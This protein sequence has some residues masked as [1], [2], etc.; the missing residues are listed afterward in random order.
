M[1]I[2]TLVLGL[3]SLVRLIKRYVKSITIIL[4]ILPTCVFAVC[5]PYNG[6]ATINEIS[7]IQQF[8][9]DDDDFLELRLLDTDIND[10]IYD[11]WSI[12]ICDS[13]TAAPND[14]RTRSVSGFTLMSPYLVWNNT[15]RGSANSFMGNLTLILQLDVLLVDENGLVIDYLS[16]NGHNAQ[17]PTASCTPAYDTDIYPGSK[18]K[19]IRRLPD[20]T[21]D[22]S[23]PSGNSQPPTEGDSNTPPPAGAA[24][25]TITDDVVIQGDNIVFELTLSNGNYN[26]D[27]TYS[28]FD[29]TATSGEDYTAGSGTISFPIGVT[30]ATITVPTFITTATIAENFYL[31]IENSV[32][33]SVPDGIAV[34]TITPIINA[35]A[36]WRSDEFNYNSTLDEI[37]DSSGNGY[38]GTSGYTTATVPGKVCQAFDFSANSTSDYVVMDHNSLNGLTDFT[39]STWI[40]TSATSTQQEILQGLGTSANDD[41][42]EIALTGNSN[43]FIKLLDV[44]QDF[45]LAANELTD[46]N[47]HHIAFTRSS[48]VVCLYID[49]A[50]K[51]CNGGY[52]TGALSIQANSLIIGQEQ[53]SVGGSFDIS[54]DFEG[55]IDEILIFDTPFLSSQIKDIFLNQNA[56]NEWDGTTRVCPAPPATAEWR[57]DEYTYSG[58]LGEII[59]SSLNGYHGQASGAMTNVL[60]KQ[61][62]AIDFSSD[63]IS[64]YAVLDH[65]SID[66][67]GD[68]T[69]SIWI[70]TS[71][72]TGFQNIIQGM[73]PGGW[74][75][76]FDIYLTDNDTLS[77]RLLS[78]TG[79]WPLAINQ[80]TDGAWHHIA[81][82]RANDQVCLYTDGT[83]EFCYVGYPTGAISLEPGTLILG[84]EQDSFGGGFDA[85]Q[86]FQGYM[87]EPLLFN[88]SKTAAEIQTIYNNQ[89][90]GINWDGTTR[91]C[92][93][94]PVNHYR[95]EYDGTGL[96][97]E[98]EPVTFKACTQSA[99]VDPT[100]AN[101][102]TNATSAT[103]SSPASG[104]IGGTGLNWTGSVTKSLAVNTAS[105]VTL[106]LSGANPTASVVCYQGG[107][108]DASCDMDFADT[109]FL[110]TNDTD[111]TTTIPNQISAK[112]SNT[113]F[114]AKTLSIQAVRTD[115]NT[116]TCS[117]LFAN[118]TDVDVDLAYQCTSPATC[119]ANSLQLTNN[120]NIYNLSV[121]PT[122][123]THTLRF[124]A[125]S[126][127]TIELLYP[128]AG[129]LLIQAQKSIDLGAGVTEVVSGNSN[130]FIVRP[131]GLKVDTSSD[132]NTANASAIDENGTVFK[133]A[134]DSFSINATAVGWVSGEDANNDGVPDSLLALN[135]NP[136]ALN[137]SG[138]TLNVSHTA[139]HPATPAAGA[140][141]GSINTQTFTAS[142]ASI[143]NLAW[144]EVGI[145]TLDAQLVDNDYMGT[146]DVLGQLNNIGRFVPDHFTLVSASGM[147]ACAAA[148]PF[149]F[150]DEPFSVTIDL[151]A[152]N[153][154][155]AVTT[156]YRAG[157]DKATLSFV[158]EN[159]N[160][161][162][163]LT[164]RLTVATP[165]WANGI[166]STSL[167]SQFARLSPYALDGPFD[168]L[169]LG[170]KLADNEASTVIALSNTLDMNAATNTV[171]SGAGCDALEIESGLS[172]R[173]GRVMIKNAY[174]PSTQQMLVP[175]TTEYWDGTNWQTVDMDSCSTIAATS[176]TLSDTAVTDFSTSIDLKDVNDPSTTVGTSDIV[177][178]SINELQAT[179]GSFDMVLDIPSYTSG[180][181]G[182]IKIELDVSA[183]PWL[184]FDWDND[185]VAD[186]AA[187]T[188]YA[189][190]GQFRGNDRI[191]YWREKR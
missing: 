10:A 17:S 116:G 177:S 75:D 30:S 173:L 106:G 166:I 77:F 74:D 128:D 139:Q 123:T 40:Q 63:S 19:R 6:L 179:N 28:M 7:K 54:Q 38:H 145:I 94:P 164:S 29:G 138:E 111:S 52:P 151:Q 36:D 88:A 109:G 175:I 181:S 132:P 190:F 152:R 5:S 91:T 154:A 115:T 170:L 183:Y 143:T 112:P 126:K 16:V 162:T 26:V 95:I 37:L 3:L 97:C 61:C 185:G 130:N 142:L 104:W 50:Y 102:S 105:T 71:H 124:S 80:L 101:L 129:Q 27:V 172:F 86:D 41:E 72:T 176:F 163:E 2:N 160:N 171:C 44:S 31:L 1:K 122:Y 49:G 58:A 127:A 12:T 153:S 65:N 96:T 55:Y 85:A 110:F 120:S 174:G 64:D 32:N 165:T 51:D 140:L 157:H 39:F 82:T 53:D 43:I 76:E 133:K 118:A 34:G 113:G 184:T 93:A 148:S 84:Q 46:G 144:S 68:L 70:N 186:G 89:N 78:A 156:N 90:A 47:W 137:F 134:G 15:D 8:K 149:T 42:V 56:G 150:M 81:F 141:S 191:I 135:D 23:E 21:G 188:M 158:A 48:N 87:D 24:T 66:G 20:G 25:L 108:I 9:S 161:G 22:W 33:V 189:T 57:F 178:G 155:N 92:P 114:N 59:D 168:S 62:N 146:G 98:T 73:H 4:Y 167:A 136:T 182:V 11:N 169:S 147:P 99:A 13:Y 121:N 69:F 79:D 83:L 107:A 180:D 45:T 100:C 131:F 117:G 18:A 14:C 187:P 67:L 103:I 125:D 35:R 60:G 159:A 119:T